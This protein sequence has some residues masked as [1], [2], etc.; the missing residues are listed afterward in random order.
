MRHTEAEG[1]DTEFR[2]KLAQ[3][4][5]AL[6]NVNRSE[7]FGI[8]DSRCMPI[9][10]HA[11]ATTMFAGYVGPRFTSGRGLL[12]LAI[13]PGGGGDAYTSRTHKDALYPLLEEFRAAA[14]TEILTAFE[15]VNDAFPSIVKAWNIWRILGPTL[16]ASCRSLDHVAYM[17][18]VPYRTRGDRMPPADAMRCAWRML[19][20]PTLAIL[21]PRAI[22]TLGMKAGSVVDKLH[23]GRL[24]AYCVP[25]TI[26]DTRI[27]DKARQ[28]HEQMAKELRDA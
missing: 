2:L 7:I 18:I 25:R 17:N 5:H 22:V 23:Q 1:V 28:V 19:M 21:Q 13:N 16:I 26:G 15:Q 6:S 12:F 10:L 4:F 24:H 9:N 8:A 3:H 14:P 20:Q 27:S 11:D